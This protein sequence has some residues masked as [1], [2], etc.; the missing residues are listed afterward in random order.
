MIYGISEKEIN[1]SKGYII[2]Q[3]GKA[4]QELMLFFKELKKRCLTLGTV[5]WDDTVIN[6]CT[7]RGCLRFYG[8]ETLALYAAHLHKDKEGIDAD[9]ILKLLPKEAV[10]MH[11]HNKV[12]YIIKI[13]I[14]H[15]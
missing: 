7:R 9:G 14:Y 3:Q 1:P 13:I 4:A 11:D 6:I 15:G 2:K 5:Y 12:N 8:D 10:V